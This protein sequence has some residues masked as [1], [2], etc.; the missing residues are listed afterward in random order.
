M[1]WVWV[2]FGLVFLLLLFLV[3][4][5]LEHWQVLDRKQ[6]VPL[7]VNILN[8]ICLAVIAW[9]MVGTNQKLEM[10]KKQQHEPEVIEIAPNF[11]SDE[12]ETVYPLESQ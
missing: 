7:I 2:V 10:M 5:L 3:I 9:S 6:R 11:E 4:Y 12:N 1:V 8:L